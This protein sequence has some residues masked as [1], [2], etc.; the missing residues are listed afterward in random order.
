MRYRHIVKHVVWRS[1]IHFNF[2]FAHTAQDT[3]TLHT[4]TP[5]QLAEGVVSKRSDI[6]RH[7]P[8]CSVAQACSER[9]LEIVSIS[10][11]PP[12][13]TGCAWSAVEMKT[14]ADIG[15]CHLSARLFKSLTSE[16][17]RAMRM[18]RSCVQRSCAVMNAV[19]L[20]K[21]RLSL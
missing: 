7:E 21:A 1:C 5:V 9:N 16:D 15:P 17:S 4:H 14:A 8:V 10:C 13:S 19:C 20:V 2:F 18:L 3:H 12:S 6:V 11:P